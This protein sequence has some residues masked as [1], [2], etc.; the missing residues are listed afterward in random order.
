MDQE[1][2]NEAENPDPILF[3][4]IPPFDLET[5]EPKRDLTKTVPTYTEVFRKTLCRLARDNR[6]VV[7]ITAAICDEKSMVQKGAHAM[8]TNSTS[9]RYFFI[10]SLK[11]F[12]ATYPYS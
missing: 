6:E 7:A 12:Q 4:S 1:N 8:A 9:G 5:G 3:H 11:V 10:V 2:Q